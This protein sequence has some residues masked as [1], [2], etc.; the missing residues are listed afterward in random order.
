[1]ARKVYSEEFRKAAVEQVVVQRHTV[2]SVAQRLGVGY[3]TIRKWVE[4]AKF[5]SDKSLIPTDLPVEQRV[6]ELEKENAR[7]RM[8]RDILKKAAAWFAKETL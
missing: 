7:L 8:E 6:R 4:R 5:N 1:M 3:G 2:S